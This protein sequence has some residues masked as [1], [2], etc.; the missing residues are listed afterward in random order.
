MKKLLA[1]TALILTTTSIAATIKIEATTRDGFGAWFMPTHQTATARTS[2]G[3]GVECLN[4][5]KDGKFQIVCQRN[6]NKFLIYTDNTPQKDAIIATPQ[7]V[8]KITTLGEK[9]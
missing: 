2:I 4:V 9:K 6:G 7:I 8:V 1:L 3:N 5:V